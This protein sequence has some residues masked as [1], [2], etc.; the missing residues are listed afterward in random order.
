MP[1]VRQVTRFAEPTRYIAT[2]VG[3][4]ESFIDLP[5]VAFSSR[6]R[7]ARR[8]R[9]SR[10]RFAELRDA[11]TIGDRQFMIPNESAEAVA[12]HVDLFERLRNCK[13]SLAGPSSRRNER[14][15]PNVRPACL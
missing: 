5:S 14:P 6:C 4:R 11:I 13:R 15:T 8:E 2:A 7:A 1:P 10:L 12:E 9:I 3:S